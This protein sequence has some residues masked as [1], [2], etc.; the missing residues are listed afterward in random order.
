MGYL[1]AQ[2]VWSGTEATFLNNSFYFSGE[3][4]IDCCKRILPLLEKMEHS[5]EPL[6]IVSHQAILRCI[7][8]YFLNG[9]LRKLPN[10][11]IPQHCLIR[12][13]HMNGEN[14]I[15][16]IRTP[17]DHNEQGV[18]KSML[19]DADESPVRIEVAV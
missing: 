16:Y 3:S 15:D 17:I 8:T 13:T 10:M 19:N 6:L 12:V 14:M 11:K 7:V 4:Y 18:V 1:I 9:D 5:E 2:Y